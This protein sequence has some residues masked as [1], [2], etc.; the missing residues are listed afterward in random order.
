LNFANSL[1]SP[2]TSTNG[3]PIST[4]IEVRD[5]NTDL[6]PRS[7]PTHIQWCAIESTIYVNPV[8]VGQEAVGIAASVVE[9]LVLTALEAVD[10]YIHTHGAGQLL[11]LN[12]WNF[13]SG[14]DERWAIH[15]HGHTTFLVL[16]HGLESMLNYMQVNRFF[17]TGVWNFF[18]HVDINVAQALIRFNRMM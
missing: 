18:D 10:A 8:L 4:A 14:Q 15:V 16:Q 5:P 13:V 6:Q 2:A 12:S 9:G 7:V 3:T 1:S 17:A 11:P